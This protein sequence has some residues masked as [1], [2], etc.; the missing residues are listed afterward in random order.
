MQYIPIA[1][2]TFCCILIYGLTKLTNSSLTMY[3]AGEGILNTEQFA[4]RQASISGA[5][6]LD[7]ARGITNFFKFLYADSWYEIPNVWQILT[8]G[9]SSAFIRITHFD[10]FKNSI[11]LIRSGYA[12]IFG[13]TMAL[14]AI[15]EK[16]GGSVLSQPFLSNV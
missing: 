6:W 3:A 15:V 11:L 13:I 5:Q 4:D 16:V 2:P 10:D 14:H 1:L 12:F 9:I 8:A 7:V